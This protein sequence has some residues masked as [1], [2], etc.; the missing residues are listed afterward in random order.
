MSK[1]R[2]YK[3]FGLHLALLAMSAFFIFA[4]QPSSADD[5]IEDLA[6]IR[7]PI[8]IKDNRLHVTFNVKGQPVRML[9]DTGASISILFESNHL[10]ADSLP[11]D[12]TIDVSFPAFKT[13]TSGNKLPKIDYQ[14]DGFSYASN[15]TI[16]IRHRH[17]ISDALSANIDGI[18]GRDFFEAYV[19]EIDSVAKIMTLYPNGTKIGHLYRYRHHLFMDDGA[20]YLVHRSRLPWEMRKT[21]KKLLLDIGYPGGIVFWDKKQFEQATSERERPALLE[22]NKGVLYFGLVRFGRLIFRNIPIFIAPEAPQQAHDRDGI[23]GATMFRPFRYAIDFNRGSLWLT[24]H[25]GNYGAGFT[26]ANDAIYTPGNEEFV[27]KDFAPKFC[28]SPKMTLNA[29]QTRI[30]S[31]EDKSRDNC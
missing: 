9:L 1:Y 19:V 4:W 5:E 24:P 15:D 13:S 31:D 23:I 2:A 16:F 21:P 20:P 14:A 17:D 25:E 6:L 30:P 28:I 18:L 11:L 10:Q 22:E 29:S 7:M 27:Q 3:A 26:I 8:D 12:D